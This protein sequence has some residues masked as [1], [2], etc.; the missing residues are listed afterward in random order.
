MFLYFKG[1]HLFCAISLVT[2]MVS[3][4]LPLTDSNQFY[5]SLV[6]LTSANFALGSLALSLNNIPKKMLIKNL[7]LWFA[8]LLLNLKVG[9]ITAEPFAAIL[10]A[11]SSICLVLS[12][13]MNRN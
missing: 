5:S 11:L 10:G 9:F 8:I 2:L 12:M 4:T 7:I 6:A 13:V 1:F 3:E